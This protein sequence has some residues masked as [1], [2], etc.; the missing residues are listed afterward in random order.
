MNELIK[1]YNNKIES[2][3]IKLKSIKKK[4]LLSSMIRLGIFIISFSCAYYF[5]G[6]TPVVILSVVLGIIAFLLLL[7]KHTDLIKVKKYLQ[8]IIEINEN[9]IQ[10][11][12]NDLSAFQYGEEYKNPLHHF[13]H[14]IDLF[15]ENSF[16]HHINRTNRKE[17]ELLLASILSSNSVDDINS[18]QE[19]IKELSDLAD[20]RQN[21]SVSTK[22]IETEISSKAIFRWLNEY[23]MFISKPVYFLGLF[24]PIITLSAFGLYYFNI[25]GE[26]VLLYMLLAGLG[27]TSVFL[28]K[29]TKLS[30]NVSEFKGIMSQYSNLLV[31]IENQE[32]KSELLELNK[33]KI[34]SESKKASEIL[35]ELS[36]HIDALDQRNNMIFGVVGNGYLLWDIKQVYRIEKWIL[37]YKSKVKNW[38]EV[39]EF[40]DAYNSLANFAYNH[41]TFN[42][43]V[44]KEDNIIQAQQ[45]GHL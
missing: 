40:F 44:L 11:L 34:K 30:N 10:G 13:S 19:S 12:N 24:F 42:Y 14:D 18:K 7:S 29:I 4:L 32:F 39:I 41:P 15:G 1:K 16:F 45:L 43:P 37:K 23:K 2:N 8:A 35:K 20:W 9:E 33:G 26:S 36:N 25:L 17:S 21:Y 6:N 5:F 31:E 22:L 3:S 38:F 28:K 27:I